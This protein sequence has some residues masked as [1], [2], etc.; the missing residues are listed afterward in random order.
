MHPNWEINF[1]IVV[2]DAYDSNCMWIESVPGLKDFT[3]MEMKYGEYSIF[4]GNRCIH[5][6]K[7]NKT[8]KTRVSMD[9]RVIPFSRYDP[10]A[11]VKSATASKYFVVGD[12][13]KFFKKQKR[14]E[15]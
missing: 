11:Q 12:Y 15:T 10:A 13:Y 4:D 5:G 3:P 6:N 1:Q 7:V 2:T 9:F 8:G 14:G